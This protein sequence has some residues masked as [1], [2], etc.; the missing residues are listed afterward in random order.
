[1]R[2]RVDYSVT[3]FGKPVNHMGKEFGPVIRS[4]TI[5]IC[6]W[7]EN[8]NVIGKILKNSEENIESL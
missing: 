7:L 3:L 6:K 8:L 2:E 5:I 4:Y 1:M